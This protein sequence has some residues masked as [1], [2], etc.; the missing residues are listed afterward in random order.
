MTSYTS[1]IMQDHKSIFSKSLLPC[2]S[3]L[4]L[5]QPSRPSYVPFPPVFIVSSLHSVNPFFLLPS[6]V[7]TAQIR[8]SGNLRRYFRSPRGPHLAIRRPSR[9]QTRGWGT[10]DR[11]SWRGEKRSAHSL[12]PRLEAMYMCWG[13]KSFSTIVYVRVLVPSQSL[14]L[15]GKIQGLGAS[16][17]YGSLVISCLVVTIAAT[18]LVILTKC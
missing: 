2:L 3:S 1:I 8:R 7:S 10:R 16:A 12:T 11:V 5:P 15:R 17:V 14:P 9:H 4:P 18:G 13:L 6:W